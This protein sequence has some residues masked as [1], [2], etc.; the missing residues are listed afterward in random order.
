MY[1]CLDGHWP[2]LCVV[3]F[4]HQCYL[5]YSTVAKTNKAQIF[6]KR[7]RTHTHTHT[8]STPGA[9]DCAR[10]GRAYERARTHRI[11]GGDCFKAPPPPVFGCLACISM[12]KPNTT[13]SA[14]ARR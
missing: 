10:T 12:H 1:A 14:Q 13:F 6:S 3:F 7:T 2:L 5:L 4:L 11:T 8:S 9:R